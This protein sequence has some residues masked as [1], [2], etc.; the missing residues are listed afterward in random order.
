MANSDNIRGSD[1][2]DVKSKSS[3]SGSGQGAS[4]TTNPGPPIPKDGQV[5]VAIMKDMGIVDYEPKVINQ[6]LEFAYRY[7]T[8][9][10]EDSKVLSH[11]ARKKAIDIDDVKLSVQMYTEQN[12]TTAPS[13]EMLLE[14]ARVKNRQPLPIPRPTCG[15]RLPPDRHCFTACNYRLKYKPKPRP[16]GY[17]MSAATKIV[18][19]PAYK[20]QQQAKIMNQNTGGSPYAMKTNVGKAPVFKINA[21]PPPP[22]AS[23]VPM[24]K[25]QI[26][27]QGT[28]G[29]AAAQFKI[30]I[31]PQGLP[32]MKRKAD[33]MDTGT[34]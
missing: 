9:V 23:D 31:N 33:E 34:F 20:P 18:T 25:I 15:L 27:P 28:A 30:Q 22:S 11:H 29:G 7:V 17:G 19:A 1:S 13:R 4:G 12:M 16:P 5:M 3:G 8:N 21:N 2:K 32:G 24:P 10:L 6:L 26:Q 14:Q